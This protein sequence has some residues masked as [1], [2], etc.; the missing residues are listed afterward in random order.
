MKRN[1]PVSQREKRLPE[2]TA[3]VSATD[4]KRRQSRPPSVASSVSRRPE[5]HTCSVTRS[6]M[7]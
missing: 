7:L 1:L 3:L 5:R 2:G 6:P 4:T